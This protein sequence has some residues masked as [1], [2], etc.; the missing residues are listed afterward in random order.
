MKKLFENP[1]SQVCK[2]VQTGHHNQHFFIVMDILGP[3]LQAIR[4]AREGARFDAAVTG[5]V[6]QSTLRALE[7]MHRCGFIHRDVKPANFCIT[8][9]NAAPQNGEDHTPHP[10]TSWQTRAC[11]KVGIASH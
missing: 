11:M 9:S 1:A 6:S 7:T 3:N 2:V 5:K 4:K 10:R 8:P